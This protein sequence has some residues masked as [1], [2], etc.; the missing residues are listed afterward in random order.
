MSKRIVAR[1]GSYTNSNNEQKGEYQNIGVILSN[2]KG[3]YGL[4]DP[5]INLAGILI[6]Q[7]IL[8]AKENKPQREKVAFSLFEDKPKNDNS[9]NTNQPY[10]QP[11]PQPQQYQQTQQAPP[12]YQQQPPSPVNGGGFS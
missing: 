8:A 4:L 6:K 9:Y 2:D 11:A 10:A 1:V 7:N 3:E 12:Q 5:A